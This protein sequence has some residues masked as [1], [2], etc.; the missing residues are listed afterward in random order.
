VRG[1]RKYLMLTHD[2]DLARYLSGH[3]RD[4]HNLNHIRVLG[5]AP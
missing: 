1:A 4:V 5:W 3:G 2:F